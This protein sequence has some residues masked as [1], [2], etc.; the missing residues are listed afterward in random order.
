M[1]R[2]SPSVERSG[3][4]D[5][6]PASVKTR[7][8]TGIPI[9][10]I[11]FYSILSTSPW[12]SFLLMLTFGVVAGVEM[13]RMLKA[14]WWGVVPTT[15]GLVAALLSLAVYIPLP[16]ACLIVTAIGAGT[17][18]W[19]ARIKRRS[20]TDVLTLGWL[21]G[22][23]A[24]GYWI[25]QA[26]PL[27]T[28]PFAPNLLILCMVPLWFGDSLGFFVGRAIGKTPLAPLIS[29]KK[30]WEGAIANG[31]GCTLA[32]LAI[33]AS[34]TVPWG[35][36]LLVGLSTSVFGQLGDLLQ[37]ALKRS[38]DVKDSGWLLPGHGGV[39]DRLDSYLLSVVPS[40]I[41]LYLTSPA[42]FHVK[43]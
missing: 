22:P 13:C 30:T 5:F 28:T 4:V 39:L 37:S 1:S 2:P 38:T 31:V 34:L 11:A 6:G 35:P 15:A 36:S 12:P 16:Y 17:V 7:L 40:I 26:T 20:R 41:I 43:H 21:A 24:A 27:S 23:I 32:A 14:P 25:Q 18:A 19:R 10:A 33:G 8:M 29:P 9:A 42:L 3:P